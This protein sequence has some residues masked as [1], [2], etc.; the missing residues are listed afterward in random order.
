MLRGIKCRSRLEELYVSANEIGLFGFWVGIRDCDG[1]IGQDWSIDFEGFACDGGILSYVGVFYM[2]DGD[3]AF[4]AFGGFKRV[5]LFEDIYEGML[6]FWDV[7]HE[8][9]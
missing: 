9:V 5:V 3:V 6:P 8:C 7:I 4:V 1:I 2:D